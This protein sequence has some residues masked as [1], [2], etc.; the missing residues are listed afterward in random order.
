[1]SPPIADDPFPDCEAPATPTGGFDDGIDESGVEFVHQVD[2][3]F[4]SDPEDFTMPLAFTVGAGVVAAD[5]DRD[6]AVDLAFPQTVGANEVW[7]GIGDGTFTRGDPGGLA[8][9]EKLS[10]GMSAADY[11]G[12]GDLDLTVTFLNGT[13]LIRL[14][15]D[16]QFTD[17]TESVG[18]AGGTGW[19]G[20]PSWGDY[21]GDGY[22][23]LYEGRHST[24]V[25]EDDSVDPAA[26]LLWSNE[27]G[28]FTLSSADRPG[29]G[30][31]EGAWLHG[32]W[33]DLDAD[34]DLDLLQVN[35]FG[36]VAAN[37][38]VWRNDQVGADGLWQWTDQASTG[39]VGVLRAPMGAAVR[40]FD[41][42]G[43]ADLWLSDIGGFNLYRSLGPFSWIEAGSVWAGSDPHSITDTSWS[44]VDIDIAG[45]GRPA[46]VVTYG[47]LPAEPGDPGH[48]PNQPDR[49]YV[50]EQAAGEQPRF[51]DRADT[52]F[53]SAEDGNSRGVGLG[54]LNN[55]GVPDLVIGHIAGPP[56]ILIGRCTTA[57]R[58]VVELRDLETANRF[59]VGAR[60]TVEAGG[61]SQTQTVRAGGRG[62]FSG[63]DPVLFFGLGVAEVTDQITVVWPNN[64]AIQTVER[65]CSHCRVVIQRED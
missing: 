1:M 12:D 17:V 51:V 38:A 20:T 45:F 24:A 7:W 28:L 52:V 2:K 35:D 19:G 6:G 57:R 42:D 61:L 56:S 9:P 29:A 30:G 23:D 33:E 64:G 40:D 18:I 43:W 60:V 31:P 37:S 14:D 21:N 34:G 10:T 8:L 62:T 27:A 63:S 54:D 50:Q 32:V 48:D 36:D 55:D 11:D 59:G 39:G 53:P 3:S 65:L 49:F 5:L 26:D 41:G 25:Y 44:V 13:A 16:R 15:S 58:L 46:V 22:L 47:P 4:L